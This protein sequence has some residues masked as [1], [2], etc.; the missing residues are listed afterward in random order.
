MNK[1]EY[2]D[3]LGSD[4]WKALRR[5]R[6]ELANYKCESC[7]SRHFL[8]VHHRKYRQIW[9]ATV[10]DLVTLCDYCHKKEHG[11]VSKFRPIKPDINRLLKGVYHKPIRQQQKPQKS[12]RMTQDEIRAVIKRNKAHSH[13][14]AHLS[15]EQEIWAK[16]MRK[17][18]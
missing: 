17:T 6:L 1:A 10:A 5:Q 7:G 2:Q 14:S 15:K 3:Y 12:T 4:H 8:Q 18:E 9:D 11:I 13:E 16:A